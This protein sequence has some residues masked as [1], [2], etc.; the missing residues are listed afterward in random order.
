MLDED[1]YTY[2]FDYLMEE[3]E[4]ATDSNENETLWVVITKNMVQNETDSAE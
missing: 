1:D 4:A 2:S 3:Y